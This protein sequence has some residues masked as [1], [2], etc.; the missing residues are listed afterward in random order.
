MELQIC[1]CYGTVELLVL[2]QLEHLAQADESLD[3]TDQ[4]AP[5]S[6]PGITVNLHCVW[7]RGG[8]RCQFCFVENSKTTP[9]GDEWP[10]CPDGSLGAAVLPSL[11][12]QIPHHKVIYGTKVD[13]L[14]TLP[15][16]LIAQDHST[17][18]R[19]HHQLHARGGWVPWGERLTSSKSTQRWSLAWVSPLLSVCACSCPHWS[20]ACPGG[21]S[22]GT[23]GCR[24]RVLRRQR[25]QMCCRPGCHSFR[26]TAR[27]H[28]RWLAPYPHP[29]SR[30]CPAGLGRRR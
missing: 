30:S 24:R 14:E 7:H 9:E 27:S 8:V 17:E 5:D 6:S 22:H 1:E 18:S 26:A 20:S 29:G 23:S 28:P 16:G 21:R 11:L 19:R 25:T 15:P 2:G 10:P 4:C 12:V 3:E 13:L